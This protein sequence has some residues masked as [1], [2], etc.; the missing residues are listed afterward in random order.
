MCFKTKTPTPPPVKEAP[1]KDV[2]GAAASEARRRAAAQQGVYENI[3]TSPLGD[4]NYGKRAG[5]L[6]QLAALG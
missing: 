6:A 1:Q 3:A 4:S 2:E 5:G